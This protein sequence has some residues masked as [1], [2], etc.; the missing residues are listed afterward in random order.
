MLYAIWIMQNIKNTTINLSIQTI[1]II[2]I[3]LI[4]RSAWILKITKTNMIRWIVL[5]IMIT[6]PPELP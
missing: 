4:I 5:I 3:M 6:R 1:Q 2:Q